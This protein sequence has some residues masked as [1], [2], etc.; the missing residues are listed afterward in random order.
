MAI[1]R[2]SGSDDMRRGGRGREAVGEFSG[3]KESGG[4]TTARKRGQEAMRRGGAQAGR[5]EE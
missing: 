2:E 4:A 3:V 1:V 5:E